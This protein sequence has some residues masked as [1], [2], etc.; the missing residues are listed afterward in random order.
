MNYYLEIA[1]IRVSFSL[2]NL[3][4]STY[5]YDAL[6]E[7]LVVNGIVE[8]R[9]HYKELLQDGYKKYDPKEIV[10]TEPLLENTPEQDAMIRAE[11]ETM[12]RDDFFKARPDDWATK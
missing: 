8:L 11:L 4:V 5:I 10:G 3:T 2:K 1:G 12:E 6:E 9:Q 7:V